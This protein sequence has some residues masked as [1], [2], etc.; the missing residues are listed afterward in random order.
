MPIASLSDYKDKDSDDE[1]R[2]NYYAGG[3]G[4][5]GGGRSL[6]R[7]VSTHGST[8]TRAC[9]PPP[10]SC[11]LAFLLTLV[12]VAPLQW[13]GNFRPDQEEESD[14]GG[15]DEGRAVY[16]SF[17]DACTHTDR[18]PLAPHAHA[19][20]HAHSASRPILRVNLRLRCTFS[21]AGK[22]GVFFGVAGKPARSQ[23]QILRPTASRVRAI[24][25]MAPLQWHRPARCGGGA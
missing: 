15:R 21:H 25:S 3:Q 24:D 20:A 13:T 14:C 6:V 19:H 5:N 23:R 10:T 11:A 8:Q 18:P 17:Q 9:L 7:H 1:D 12:V 4:R 16:H 22:H 2:Q